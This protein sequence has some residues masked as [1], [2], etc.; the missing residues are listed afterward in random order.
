MWRLLLVLS[1]ACVSFVNAIPD[2]IVPRFIFYA[3]PAVIPNEPTIMMHTLRHITW[4]WFETWATCNDTAVGPLF[5]GTLRR[6]NQAVNCTLERKNTA[7]AYAAYRVL[8]QPI[9]EAWQVSNFDAMMAEFGLDP[10]NTSNDTSTPIGLGNYIGYAIVNFQRQD[11]MNSRGDLSQLNN[12]NT[13][14]GFP[15]S[16][17]TGYQ[18]IQTTYNL[19]FPDR[20]QPQIEIR[21]AGNG[22]FMGKTKIFGDSGI[23]V[24]QTYATPQI[25][26]A[27]AFGFTSPVPFMTD[28]DQ[29]YARYS[30]GGN[31]RKQAYIDQA[32]DVIAA[33]ANLTDARKIEA[34][35]FESKNLA[36]GTPLPFLAT[37]SRGTISGQNPWTVD[38]FVVWEFLINNAVWDATLVAWSVKRKRDAVRPVTAIRFLKA[39]DTIY[40]WGGPG[41]GNVYQSGSG[42]RSWLRTM[43]HSEY[44]SG[45]SCMCAAFAEANRQWYGS[46]SMYGYSFAVTAGSSAIEP[47]VVPAVN[48]TLGPFATFT[49]YANTCGYSRWHG[50]VHFRQSIDDALAKCPRVA[51]NA[52][53]LW[54]RYLAGNVTVPVS[55]NDRSQFLAPDYAIGTD[56]NLDSY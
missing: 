14:W 53:A 23:Q 49:Q 33:Q 37:H 29:V 38:D 15:Y 34:E 4:A 16:D 3:R 51:Q 52:A 28:F 12:S 11:G 31:A 43:A 1:F 5:L 19:Q 26:Y 2:N 48:S 22:P 42:F 9:H 47:G 41:K 36:F 40:S 21:Y 18:P 54:R 45:S 17:Y 35:Y 27:K 7:Y 56:V 39:D 46:D 44:P 13:L 50:G 55:T 24:V 25:R 6:T 32:N 8:S 30:G 20:F 10:K